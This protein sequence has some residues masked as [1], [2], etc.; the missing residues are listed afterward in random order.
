M[1]PISRRKQTKDAQLHKPYSRVSKNTKEE[2]LNKKEKNLLKNTLGGVLTKL[3]SM[4]NWTYASIFRKTESSDLS[5]LPNKN[6]LKLLSSNHLKENADE[7]M[8]SASLAPHFLGYTPQAVRI[9]QNH[10]KNEYIKEESKKQETLEESV[11]MKKQEPY[12]SFVS[13]YNTNSTQKAY[14]SLCSSMSMDKEKCQE[15]NIKEVNPSIKVSK[16]PTHCLDYESKNNLGKL[17][18]KNYSINNRMSF[19]WT[20]WPRN[21]STG[22]LTA[23]RE[24]CRQQEI[25][26]KNSITELQLCKS[27]SMFIKEN[28][29]MK[30]ITTNAETKTRSMGNNDVKPNGSKK[31]KRNI[32]QIPEKRKNFYN[33]FNV[34]KNNLIWTARNLQTNNIGNLKSSRENIE[35]EKISENYQITN[36]INIQDKEIN[37]KQNK[38]SNFQT[39][40]KETV[41]QKQDLNYLPIN[42]IKECTKTH[43][44][45]K[46]VLNYNA[47]KNKNSENAT[48][49]DT[50]KSNEEPIMS[51]EISKSQ[52]HS[53]F[54]NNQ[55][56]RKR[57]GYF[58]ALE[59]D[60]EE[61]FGPYDDVDDDKTA[62]K[63]K[64]YNKTDDLDFKKSPNSQKRNTDYQ[65]PYFQPRIPLLKESV[66]TN[67]S[68]MQDP[69]NVNNIKNNENSSVNSFESNLN[70][71]NNNINSTEESRNN[72]SKVSQSNT[73]TNSLATKINRNDKRSLETNN[74]IVEKD[75]TPVN[76]T[77]SSQ[78]NLN[79]VSVPFSFSLDKKTA[80]T[81]EKAQEHVSIS[82]NQQFA[83]NMDSEKNKDF[84]DQKKVESVITPSVESITE[85]NN[86]KH[87]NTVY[88]EQKI[89]VSAFNNDINKTSDVLQIDNDKQTISL[90]RKTPIFSVNTDTF[91]Q[92][93]DPSKNNAS[94]SIKS[95]T[96]TIMEMDSSPEKKETE[97]QPKTSNFNFTTPMSDIGNI[98]FEFKNNESNSVN[99]ESFEKEEPLKLDFNKN[100]FKQEV[101]NNFTSVTG[102]SKTVTDASH[103]FEK[104]QQQPQSDEQKT[105]QSD[106]DNIKDVSSEKPYQMAKPLEF[107]DPKSVPFS[108]KSSTTE[109]NKPQASSF[110]FFESTSNFNPQGK[111]SI[112]TSTNSSKQKDVYSSNEHEP[113]F[114]ESSQSKSSLGSDQ[115]STLPFTFGQNARA[116]NAT[117]DA[118]TT[119][120]FSFGTV[121]RPN[122][123]FS[124]GQSAPN[125]F[126]FQTMVNN[127][128]VFQFGRNENKAN[129]HE[130]TFNFN[131]PVSSGSLT[132]PSSPFVFGQSITN[133]SG[134]Q[135]APSF[136]F[137]S[138]TP[139]V[140]TYSPFQTQ[141][142]ATNTPFLFNTPQNTIQ[143]PNISG[144]N[145]FAFTPNTPQSSNSGRKIAAPKSR[146]RRK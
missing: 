83:F 102:D 106:K 17:Q 68:R 51:P 137:G 116:I 84:L 24:I 67:A 63:R 122:Q 47:Q 129:S 65:Q 100:I 49:R 20:Q 123:E 107:S 5:K 95:G 132:S 130:F 15:C 46:P 111:Q 145:P 54:V 101:S 86:T 2:S 32:V 61:I 115:I 85:A 31:E 28:T 119:P 144:S 82:S 70:I 33:R 41:I 56:K 143:D 125:T 58:S 66:D 14:N 50:A 30:N 22:I 9:R 45:E 109:N 48:N 26:L 25:M 90:E 29:S 105:L 93:H 72:G 71:Q 108:F 27:K 44:Q 126:S 135:M 74:L 76:I 136:N 8:L 146:L 7:S 35:P 140:S 138:N 117:T 62:F 98:L 75:Q 69:Y 73:N 4:L 94:V 3:L 139:T 81:K 99:K 52:N 113:N 11:M 96:D 97:S 142:Q 36:F 77:N 141:T 91:H 128:P 53:F 40:N 13:S 34:S 57:S 37:H 79:D 42:V 1:G 55:H 114:T 131:N 12:T 43:I 80:S 59:E 133:S 124:F 89:P 64:K 103:I 88:L 120:I 127:P 112:Q 19:D 18:R 87:Q 38:L 134:Q 110:S 23:W 92:S 104:S 78:Y 21:S 10:F 118:S 121:N 6:N 39:R 16:S 60:L